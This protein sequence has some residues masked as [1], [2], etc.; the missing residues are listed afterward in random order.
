MPPHGGFTWGAGATSAARLAVLWATEGCSGMLDHFNDPATIPVGE[1][2]L[3]YA[4]CPE[5]CYAEITGW[6]L[7]CGGE[8]RAHAGDGL[9]GGI[10]PTTHPLPGSGSPH[11]IIYHGLCECP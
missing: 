8:I 1:Y 6:A 4:G 10:N 11:V 9:V 3:G 7:V 5:G 2:D